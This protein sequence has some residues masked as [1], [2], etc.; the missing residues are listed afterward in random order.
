[1]NNKKSFKSVEAAHFSRGLVR[2]LY[3]SYCFSRIPAT[4]LSLFQIGTERAALPRDVLPHPRMDYDTVICCLADAFGWSLFNH[5]CGRHPVLKQLASS[6]VVSKLT[7]QFPSTTAAEV[8]A[9][10]TGLEVGQSPVLEWEYYDA[11]AGR[12]INA[13]KFTFAGQEE[14]EMLAAAGYRPADLLPKGSFLPALQGA[15]IKSYTIIKDEYAFSSYSLGVAPEA[16]VIPYAAFDQG[17]EQ[18]AGLAAQSGRQYCYCY[19][20]DIDTVSHKHGPDSAE[21]GAVATYFLDSLG[22]HFLDRLPKLKSRKILLLLFAD[23]GQVEVKK[24]EMLYLKRDFPEILGMLR[25]GKD[26]NSLGP[27]GGRGDYF[28]HLQPQ[29]VE[30]VLQRLSNALSDRAE[31]WRGKDLI[32]QGFFGSRPVCAEFLANCPD[33]FVISYAG[34]GFGWDVPTRDFERGC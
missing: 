12:S 16:T 24:Q 25:T 23:H 15:G 34:F 5:S 28:L 22:K 20:A 21:A 10:F 11:R 17:L 6:G 29:Y 2:P 33:L 9:I 4:V 19:F 30:Q 31:I 32:D 7:A 1:M 26:G 13:L 14:R 3:D 27:T 18:L 8:T